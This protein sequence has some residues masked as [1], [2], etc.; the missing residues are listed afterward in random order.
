M[1]A[2][3]A[4]KEAS[5]KEKESLDSGIICHGILF[6]NEFQFSIS[7]K[8][9]ACQVKFPFTGYVHC[10]LPFGSKDAICVIL[11]LQFVYLRSVIVKN[12]N[13]LP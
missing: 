2:P 8:G 12:K 10:D 5:N 4:K 13:V 6:R 1:D 11:T 9:G 3:K 7:Y